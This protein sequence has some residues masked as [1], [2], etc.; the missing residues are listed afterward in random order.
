VDRGLIV[1]EREREKQNVLGGKT[2]RTRSYL[3]RMVKSHATSVV[4]DGHVEQSEVSV[5]RRDTQ[6]VVATQYFRVS[7]LHDFRSPTHGAFAL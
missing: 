1:L 3:G 7:L 2:S 6:V 4:L 5:S